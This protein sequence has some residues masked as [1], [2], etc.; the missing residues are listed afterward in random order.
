MK[1]PFVITPRAEQDIEDIWECIPADSVD[2]AG[3]V[4]TALE[5]AFYRLAKNLAS[6][7]CAKTWLTAGIDSCLSTRTGLFIASRRSRY[8]S[9]GFFTP[10]VTSRASLV[11]RLGNSGSDM[12]QSGTLSPIPL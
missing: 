9:S 4:L 6:V 5:R 3:R 10:L 12:H 1:K 7:T 2:A 11:L 8:K